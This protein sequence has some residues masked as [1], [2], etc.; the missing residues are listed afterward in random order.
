M[1]QT[2]PRSRFADDTPPAPP[3]AAQADPARPCRA[4]ILVVDDTAANIQIVAAALSKQYEIMVATGGEAALALLRETDKPDLIL[5]DIMMPEMDGHEVCRRIK[6]DPATWDIPI[7]FLTAKGAV[8]DQQRG[9]N[10]GAV[11]YITKPIEIPLLLARVGVHIQLKRKS[12]Q[13]EKL[14]MLDGLTEI[15]NRRALDVRLPQECQRTA[16]EGVPLAVLMIDIDHFKAFNDR[17]GHGAGDECLRRVAQ[18]IE[19]VPHRP[20]DFVARYGGE[21]FCV[22]LPNCDRAGALQVAENLRSAVAALDIPHAYSSAA[23]HVT[24]SIGFSARWVAGEETGPSAIQR[25]ADAALYQ[26]KSQG[27]NRVVGHEDGT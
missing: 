15:A 26:A 4:R 7:I 19:A 5:L 8:E 9:F 18:T 1:P 6:E 17:Y 21:E 24:I 3:F 12:E 14:A 2:H 22:I 16:R 23:R 10:L 13:L 11:D 20:G 25:E 27:R